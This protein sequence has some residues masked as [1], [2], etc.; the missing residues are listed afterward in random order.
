MASDV[1]TLKEL[2]EGKE[3]ELHKRSAHWPS[4]R[5]NHLKSNPTCAL[6]EGTRKLEVHHIKPFHT[7]PEFE[8]DPDNL[9]TL[10]EDKGHGVYCHLFFG[11]LG[12]YKS[13]NTNVLE[14]I[15]VW[16][17]RLKNRPHDAKD[18]QN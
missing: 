3:P 5:K 7:H 10:C 13:I 9:I 4:V 15:K 17:E 14:D 16:K 1:T 12:N 2:N 11:H 6:C 18:L 8:L